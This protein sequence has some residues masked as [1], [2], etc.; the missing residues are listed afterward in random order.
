VNGVDELRRG[1]TA[2]G[3]AAARGQG[4]LTSGGAPRDATWTELR[5]GYMD[6]GADS[7]VDGEQESGREMGRARVERE[8]R[9]S[10]FIEEREEMRGWPA[11][12]H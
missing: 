7:S 3:G 4:F 1:T 12:C 10:V 6:N 2:S 11:S 9:G 5:W 8:L